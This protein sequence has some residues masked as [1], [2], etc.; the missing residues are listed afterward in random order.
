MLYNAPSIVHSYVPMVASPLLKEI[1]E[2]IHPVVGKVKLPTGFG[3]MVTKIE[4]RAWHPVALLI[5][6]VA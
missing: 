2:L 3:L 5:K 6:L 4:S 1:G